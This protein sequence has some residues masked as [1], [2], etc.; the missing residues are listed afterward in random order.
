MPPADGNQRHSR[1]RILSALGQGGMGA[2]Q[3]VLQTTPA[4][5]ERLAVMKRPRPE[6]LRHPEFADLFW[7]E[8]RIAITLNHPNV[9]HTYEA[10]EDAA[11]YFLLLEFLRGQSYAQLIDRC[12]YEDYRV[13]LEVVLGALQGLEY[14]HGSKH[15][16]G[17]DMAIVH[18]DISPPNL[19]LTY[20]GQVKVLDFGIA[21]PRD[22]KLRTREGVIKGKVAY[23][24]PEQ[25]QGRPLDAR[26]DLYAVG[27]LLWE[28]TAGRSRF[29]G[30]SGADIVN[31]VRDRRAPLVP[32]A[33]ARGLPPLADEICRRALAYDPAERYPSAERF[34][35]DVL[36]LAEQCG[37]R[38]KPRALGQSLAQRF[39]AERQA[40]QARIESELRGVAPS[41]PPPPPPPAPRSPAG[42]APASSE[43]AVSAAPSRLRYVL[44]A[45]ML[46]AIA[47]GGLKLGAL[48]SRSKQAPAPRASEAA[49]A[50]S[51]VPPPPI[52]PEPTRLEPAPAVPAVSVRSVP[53]R[54]RAP[55]KPKPASDEAA[56]DFGGRR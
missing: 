8:A 17:H 12:G 20:E 22:S 24:P 46:A 30:V 18:R 45:L 28:A 5:V 33:A 11:G 14:A 38:L 48:L 44:L 31:H 36:A 50:P 56:T 4:G 3:L 2:V 35:D 42:L 13:S 55:S 41:P 47:I 40:L 16:S 49:N 6:L 25:M 1:F 52:V 23:M 10:G 27:V 53:K 39:S 37:G 34:H 15:P 7:E 9:V 29:A 43:A 51:V 19:F 26:A 32:G 21:K 54:P